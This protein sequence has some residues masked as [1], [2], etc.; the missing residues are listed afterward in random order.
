MNKIFKNYHV[1]KSNKSKKSSIN[2]EP[3]QAN[4]GTQTNSICLDDDLDA[5]VIEDRDAETNQ[6]ILNVLAAPFKKG[7]QVVKSFHSSPIR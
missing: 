2:N 5:L 3:V 6:I 4:Q 7:R 1:V